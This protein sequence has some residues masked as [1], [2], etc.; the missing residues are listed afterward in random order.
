MLLVPHVAG[1]ELPSAMGADVE[2]FADR[3]QWALPTAAFTYRNVG[4]IARV[5]VDSRGAAG[6]GQVD[7]YPFHALEHDQASGRLRIVLCA[8][9]DGTPRITCDVPGAESFEVRRRRE[10]SDLALRIAHG[11]GYTLLTFDE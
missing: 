1:V 7:G 4:R 11:D 5:E 2:V 9:A 3:A 6:V 8:D 10:G